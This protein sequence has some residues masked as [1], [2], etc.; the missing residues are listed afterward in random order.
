MT[1]LGRTRSMACFKGRLARSGF[2][3]IRERL[4]QSNSVGPDGGQ[5]LVDRT[6]DSLNVLWPKP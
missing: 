1:T 6:V 3:V 5:I 2:K 4:V